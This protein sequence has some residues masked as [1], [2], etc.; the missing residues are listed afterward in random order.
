[1]FSARKDNHGM[2]SRLYCEFP[3]RGPHY[4]LKVHDLPF[5]RSSPTVS[6]KKE[7][8]NVDVGECRQITNVKYLSDFMDT[9]L[10]SVKVKLGLCFGL[11]KKCLWYLLFFSA[12]F[13]LYI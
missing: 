1:M 9:N 5:T 10:S 3:R 8:G 11:F 6:T 12:I 2:D 13:I 4:L 7:S